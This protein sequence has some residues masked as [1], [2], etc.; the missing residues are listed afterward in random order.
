MKMLLS[1]K[2]TLKL[3]QLISNIEMLVITKERYTEY[4][5]F[6]LGKYM[7]YVPNDLGNSRKA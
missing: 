4:S 3:I 5:E 6:K 1:Y 7:I 2:S